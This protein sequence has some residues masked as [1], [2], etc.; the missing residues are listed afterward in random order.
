MYTAWINIFYWK[1]QPHTLSEDVA[2]SGTKKEKTIGAMN[3]MSGLVAPRSTIGRRWNINN[4]KYSVKTYNGHSTTGI[5]QYQ[6]TKIVNLFI[7]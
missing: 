3:I 7:I 1:G 6:Y 4:W 2:K 5:I